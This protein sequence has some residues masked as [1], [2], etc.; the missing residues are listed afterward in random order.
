MASVIVLELGDNS[1]VEKLQEWGGLVGQIL[2]L[3]VQVG[4]TKILWL[5]WGIIEDKEDLKCYI[6]GLNSYQASFLWHG[7]I[8]H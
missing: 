7:L 6:F 5:P 3:D 1:V 8:L 2:G 4:E